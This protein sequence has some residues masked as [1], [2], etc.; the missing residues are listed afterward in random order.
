MTDAVT[1]IMDAITAIV[2]G[3]VGIFVELFS[4]TGIV[5][6]FWDTTAGNLT[7]VGTFLLLAFGFG[8]VRFGLNW[9][10]KLIRMKG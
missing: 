2:S 6:V 3:A 10:T 9:V 7:I 5:S 8:L 4:D 1:A